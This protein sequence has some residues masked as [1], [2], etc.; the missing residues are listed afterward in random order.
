MTI[1]TLIAHII[2]TFF[3]MANLFWIIFSVSVRYV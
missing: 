2:L 1:V 3:T